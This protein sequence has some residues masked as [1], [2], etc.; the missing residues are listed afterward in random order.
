MVS[1]SSSGGVSGSSMIRLRWV[2]KPHPGL[3]A[4]E[5][6]AEAFACSHAR[7]IRAF[8]APDSLAAPAA[9]L[10]CGSSGGHE[11]PH[12]QR[13]GRQCAIAKSVEGLADACA[14][15]DAGSVGD[16]EFYD[17]PPS[18]TCRQVYRLSVG[19]AVDSQV[20]A[21]DIRRLRASHKRD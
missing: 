4:D 9:F 13:G 17:D 16:V 18:D 1:A 20:R 21:G 6:K 10:P 14:W 19:A 11:R 5:V 8:E 12:R 15:H 7:V 3:V 2:L